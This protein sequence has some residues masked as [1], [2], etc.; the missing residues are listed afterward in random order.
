MSLT[1]KLCIFG[2][3]APMFLA[4]VGS[5]GVSAQDGPWSVRLAERDAPV[6]HDAGLDA[7]P[8]VDSTDTLQACY[9]GQKYWNADVLDAGGPS[10]YIPGP[11]D[12][13]DSTVGRIPVYLTSDR[14]NDVNLM[15]TNEH[16]QTVWARV[17]FFP[18]DNGYHC[19]Q[20][21]AF[22]PGNTGWVVIATGVLTGAQFEVEFA[23]ASSY[24]EGYV[25]A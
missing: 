20:W 17:C 24:V 16:P 6:V 2:G 11:E 7:A 9:D 8:T 19:N 3:L 12:A 13:P 5:N 25:A 15:V 23:G 10:N 18:T 14:C 21:T 4:A 22:E 1:R